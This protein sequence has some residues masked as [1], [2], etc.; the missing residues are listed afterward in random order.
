ALKHASVGPEQM[1]GGVLV[2]EPPPG[3]GKVDLTVT[4]NGQT[5]RFA[6]DAKPAALA[7]GALGLAACG[8]GEPAADSP[9]SVAD[10]VAPAPAPAPAATAA[11]AIEGPAAGKWR[12]SMTTMG[13]IL[14][15]SEVCYAEQV[16][17]AEAEKMQQQA[18]VTCPEQSRSEERRV[19]KE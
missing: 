15:P 1:A 10:A 16:N 4:F 19:G 2:V 7:I 5:H 9:A 11:P 3:G 18:G 8:P 17:L 13:Q 12:I 6:F 14:P